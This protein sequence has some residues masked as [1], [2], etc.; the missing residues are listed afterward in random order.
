MELEKERGITIASAA[1]YVDWKGTHIN[2]ID[3][4]GHVDFTIEVE[5]ALQ[6]PGRSHPGSL[7]RWWGT[8]PDHHRRPAAQALQRSPGGLCQQM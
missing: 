8:V 1:T 4:P 2:I 6:G 3:T 7:F 5:R